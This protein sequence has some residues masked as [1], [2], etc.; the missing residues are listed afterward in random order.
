M[1]AN[2]ETTDL[3]TIISHFFTLLWYACRM[4]NNIIKTCIS[5]AF[6]K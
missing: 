4:N 2:R 6:Y 5:R 3:I 1:R